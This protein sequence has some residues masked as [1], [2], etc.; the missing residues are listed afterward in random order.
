M[1]VVLDRDRQLVD[2]LIGHIRHDVLA[3]GCL[4]IASSP[5]RM[6]KFLGHRQ[7]VIQLLYDILEAPQARP[8]VAV[9]FVLNFHISVAE[10]EA[11]IRKKSPRRPPPSVSGRGRSN[12]YRKSFPRSR[13]Q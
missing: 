8:V 9:D 12:R 11:P 6:S 4:S 13:G 10:K 7:T 5:A 2:V 3:A 1:Q